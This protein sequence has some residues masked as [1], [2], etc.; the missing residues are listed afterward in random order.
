MSGYAAG[1]PLYRA[2][3]GTVKAPE[4]LTDHFGKP[5]RWLH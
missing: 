4:Y 3:G 1:V 5:C 2:G